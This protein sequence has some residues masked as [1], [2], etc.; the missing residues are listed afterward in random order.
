MMWLAVV[1]LR[2]AG[3]NGDVKELETACALVDLMVHSQQ[4]ESWFI[5]ENFFSRLIGVSD[6]M[7]FVQL[8]QILEQ[9]GIL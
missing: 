1:D 2:I 4:V 3:E 5:F 6:S 9:G 7:N 8:H